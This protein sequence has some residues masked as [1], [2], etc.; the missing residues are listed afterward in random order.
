MAIA[1]CGGFK[2]NASDFKIIK[3]VLTTVDKT[4]VD[5]YFVSKVCGGIKCDSSVFEQVKYNGSNVICM[6]GVAPTGIVS[7]TCSIQF[8]DGKFEIRDGEICVK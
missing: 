5:G 7:T 3:G 6:I 1:S 4:T 2:F 8:D